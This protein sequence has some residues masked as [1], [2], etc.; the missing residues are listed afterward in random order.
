MDKKKVI[1]IVL[2]VLFVLIIVFLALT[3]RKMV[4][5]NDLSQKVAQYVSHLIIGNFPKEAMKVASKLFDVEM[6]ESTNGDGGY[7]N[8]RPTVRNEWEYNECLKIVIPSFKDTQKID[9]PAGSLE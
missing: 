6:R 2:L 8:L 1:K 5:L 3:I 7:K 9:Q 4:I